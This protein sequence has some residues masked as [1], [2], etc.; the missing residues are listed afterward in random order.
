MPSIKYLLPSF[1]PEQVKLMDV[2]VPVANLITHG[3]PEKPEPR[4]DYARINATRHSAGEHH[5]NASMANRLGM[6]T[7]AGSSHSGL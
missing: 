7:I 6:V 3:K 4:K 5:K 2:G 1:S